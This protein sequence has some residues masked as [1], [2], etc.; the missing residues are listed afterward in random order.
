MALERFIPKS[1]DIFIRNS[2]DFEVAKF[3]HLNTIVEYINNN[4]AKPA[5]LNGYVQ[6]NNNSALGGDAGLF[7]DNVNK[8]LGVG[9]VTP[10]STLIVNGVTGIT[11][12]LYLGNTDSFLSTNRFQILNAGNTLAMVNVDGGGSISTTGR[13]QIFNSTKTNI[14]Q[15]MYYDGATMIFRPMNDGVESTRF[16]NNAQDKT[17]I[18]MDGVSGNVDIG[19]ATTLG[20]RLGVKGSGSTSAT[21]ALLVQNSNAI[22]LLSV[23]N[24]GNIG[25]GTLTPGTILPDIWGTGGY[26]LEL[27]GASNEATGIFLRRGS[28]TGIGL[29]IWSRNSAGSSYIDNRYDSTGANGIILRIRT[30]GT[31]RTV[32]AFDDEFGAKLGDWTNNRANAVRVEGDLSFRSGGG[33]RTITGPLNTSLILNALPLNSNEGVILQYSGLTGFILNNS[34]NVGIGTSAPT[35]KLEVQGNGLFKTTTSSTPLVVAHSGSIAIQI[36]N[37][38]TGNRLRLSTLTTYA[39]IDAPDTYLTINPNGAKTNVGTSSNLN[40]TLGIKGNGSTGSTSSLL[41]QNSAGTTALEILD[42]L[43]VSS[44]NS[45]LSFTNN[46]LTHRIANQSFTGN[47]IACLGNLVIGGSSQMT[48]SNTTLAF[49]TSTNFSSIASPNGATRSGISIGGDFTNSGSSG[50]TIG[51]N[52]NIT[53]ALNTS[54]GNVTL[55]QLNIT[56]TVNTTGGTTLQRGFYYNP[57]L[58]GTVGFTHRAIQ[59]T[60]GG[61][62][63]NTATPDATAALQVDSTTQGFLPPRMTTAQRNAIV[64]PANSL[65]VFDTDV[66]N[67]CYRRDGVW[68]QATFAAV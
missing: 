14:A 4:S 8:R 24:N 7:W 30:A 45:T 43:V 6:F 52:F 3:G 25:I 28:F 10:S 37:N 27:L 57:T 13:F 51:N 12:S 18:R 20:A 50:T 60:S 59:T 68:V 32:A 47:T 21:T 42:N 58:T 55:N 23:L 1:P 29:D 38:A 40:A 15:A 34:G 41:V 61:A 65:I 2:Q 56:N 22:T 39:S 19:T 9:T 44:A 63:I 17:M 33:P 5:G 49:Q 54:I 64:S 48:F 46:S 35:Y 36:E 31:P 26:S 67:L 62:Y 11:N 66:Q 16:S 53:T